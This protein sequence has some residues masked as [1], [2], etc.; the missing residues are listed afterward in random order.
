[1]LGLIV[2]IFGQLWHELQE[3]EDDSRAQQDFA[4]VVQRDRETL[5]S[6]RKGGG[7]IMRKADGKANKKQKLSKKQV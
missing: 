6:A 4:N 1:M 5:P 3:D 7:G 2:F